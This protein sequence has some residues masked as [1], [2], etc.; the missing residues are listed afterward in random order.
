[1]V[2]PDLPSEVSHL[3]RYTEANIRLVSELFDLTHFSKPIHFA[4][5]ESRLRHNFGHFSNNYVAVF[6]MLGLSSLFSNWRPVLGLVFI[7]IG[8]LSVRKH[9]GNLFE[10]GQW[11]LTAS[12]LHT[13]LYVAAALIILQSSLPIVLLS[14]IGFGI[15]MVLTHAVLTNN[16]GRKD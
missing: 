8:V 9:Q 4:E 11:Q 14:R 16:L 2:I 1:M 15:L 13:L 5:I 6:V 10:L 7:T 3:I 12:R